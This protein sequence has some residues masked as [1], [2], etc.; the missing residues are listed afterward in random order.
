MAVTLARV[1][2]RTFWVRPEQRT[3]LHAA[4]MRM[5]ASLP[6]A[7]DVSPNHR[8]RSLEAN[9]AHEG[10]R[11]APR[12]LE[13]A[14]YLSDIRPK[15]DLR[16]G[17]RES[18]LAT[19]TSERTQSPQHG[20]RGALPH[21]AR[22][23]QLDVSEAQDRGKHAGSFTFGSLGFLNQAQHNERRRIM[24]EKGQSWQGHVE[25][26]E[27]EPS[28]SEKITIRQVPKN[29]ESNPFVRHVRGS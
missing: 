18:R 13:T 12:H 5:Q 21:A 3:S 6:T 8:S 25:D 26:T 11:G 4:D 29:T 9:N 20:A 16:E 28:D 24:I 15:A 7:N 19:A 27:I 22:S 10:H 17:T 1:Q 2:M 14:E 23:F